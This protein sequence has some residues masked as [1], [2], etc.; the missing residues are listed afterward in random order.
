MIK[1]LICAIALSAALPAQAA[2]ERKSS[3]RKASTNRR[4][5]ST[6]PANRYTVAGSGPLTTT[7]SAPVKKT[8][9]QDE[10]DA[11]NKAAWDD[12]VFAYTPFKSALDDMVSHCSKA[13]DDMDKIAKSMGFIKASGGW[14]VA[15]GVIGAAAGAVNIWQTGEQEKLEDNL[16]KAK[17]RE[18]VNIWIKERDSSGKA[19]SYTTEAKEFCDFKSALDEIKIVPK[20]KKIWRIDDK[21]EK[22]KHEYY[23][24]DIKKAD[25]YIEGKAENP[26]S[27]DLSKNMLF[28]THDNFKNEYGEYTSDLKKAAGYKESESLIER[29]VITDE[30]ELKTAK[31]WLN[32]HDDSIK[33]KQA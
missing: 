5:H 29:G 26:D 22:N 1:I 12:F 3:E 4:G 31:N 14:A 30:R 21:E 19:I 13:K 17:E 6:R 7:T 27:I 18:G 32:E 23:T 25:G 16:A 33:K 24:N 11:D 15:G 9:T 28:Y 10:I 8:K 2:R 20:E